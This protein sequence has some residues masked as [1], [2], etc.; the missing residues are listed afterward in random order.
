MPTRT[1]L[2]AEN[3]SAAETKEKA[4]GAL[5]L[6]REQT[7]APIGLSLIIILGRFCAFINWA[8][9]ASGIPTMRPRC[10]AC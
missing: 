7:L 2:L 4:L 9:T 6:T 5:H 3:P 10:K 1:Q 8:H